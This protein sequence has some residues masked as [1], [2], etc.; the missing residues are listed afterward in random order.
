MNQR[1]L[2]K[3]S[4]YSVIIVLMMLFCLSKAQAAVPVVVLGGYLDEIKTVSDI[5][6]ID[7]SPDLQSYIFG[8]TEWFPGSDT[9]P[10]DPFNVNVSH[11]QKPNDI[12]SPWGTGNAWDVNNTIDEVLKNINYRFCEE[13]GCS[14]T[15]CLIPMFDENSITRKAGEICGIITPECKERAQSSLC[16]E[17]PQPT[18][19]STEDGDE[20]VL[21]QLREL[22]NKACQLRSSLVQTIALDVHVV[23]DSSALIEDLKAQARE[24]LAREQLGEESKIFID[25]YK[26][27]FVQNVYDY[28]Y[29]DSFDTATSYLENIHFNV[30]NPPIEQEE[31]EAIQKAVESSLVASYI[32]P[33]KPEKSPGFIGLDNIFNEEQGGGWDQWFLALQDNNNPYGIYASAQE[34][35]QEIA[36]AKYQENLAK[37]TAYQGVNPITISTSTIMGPAGTPKETIIQPGSLT[38]ANMAAVTQAQLNLAATPEYAPAKK[39]LTPPGAQQP[40][41]V[42]DKATGGTADE[43]VE[44]WSDVME[45]SLTTLEDIF[46]AC[47]PEF[48]Q[49]LDITDLEDLIPDFDFPEVPTGLE[50]CGKY[51]DICDYYP[52]VCNMLDVSLEGT[53]ETLD[54][55]PE[56]CQILP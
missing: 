15:D 12:L 16:S 31:M 28:L 30:Q 11:T 56:V 47:F 14:K 33:G 18:C 13:K 23:K 38:A 41:P 29:K 25:Q 8:K 37:F 21:D 24:K 55:P 49:E 20:K 35:A 6:D 54:L 53:C 19:Q 42:K 44:W 46:C 7:T 4:L 22:R 17:D 32:Q 51:F 36:A 3:F 48:C 43:N 50:I 26:Q 52:E 5:S 34:A 27:S 40:S 10:P 39:A 1:S 45:T 2:L 9:I